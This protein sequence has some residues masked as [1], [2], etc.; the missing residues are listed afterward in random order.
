M[1]TYL[2]L[3]YTDPAYSSHM[4]GLAI[5]RE[6]KFTVG[7]A[8]AL[9]DL[10]KLARI[11]PGV[12]LDE[13]FIDVPDLDTG[14]AIVLQV[15]DNDTANNLVATTTIGQAG[16]RLDI[17]DVAAGILPKKYTAANDLV[18]KVATGPTTGTTAVSFTG[19]MRYHYY[20]QTSQ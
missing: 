13:L 7:T 14:T 12:F 11:P 18:V 2:A 9:N 8:L 16:G 5:T 10:I 6:F 1:A 19:F 3:G 4:A 17:D 20:G 15:G